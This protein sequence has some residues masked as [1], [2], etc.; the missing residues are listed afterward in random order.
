MPETPKNN[1]G[2]V[3]DCEELDD[4]YFKTI[5]KQENLFLCVKKQQC[6]FFSNIFLPLRTICLL[7]CGCMD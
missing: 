5:G 6:K 1:E 7:D 3:E 4:D 2:E